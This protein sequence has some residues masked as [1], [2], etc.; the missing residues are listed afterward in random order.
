METDNEKSSPVDKITLTDNEKFSL[1]DKITLVVSFTFVA[2]MCL[3][4]AYALGHI[5]GYDEGIDFMRSLDDPGD[6]A[7]SEPP[8]PEMSYPPTGLF[9]PSGSEDLPPDAPLPPEGLKI[10]DLDYPSP[11]LEELDRLMEELDREEMR[12]KNL[13]PGQQWLEKEVEEGQLKI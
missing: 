6:I 9:D 10:P 3:F 7:L 11:S 2:F 13:D 5:D 12:Y 4:G 1:V 8:M